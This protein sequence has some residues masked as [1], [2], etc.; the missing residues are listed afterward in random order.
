MHSLHITEWSSPISSMTSSQVNSLLALKGFERDSKQLPIFSIWELFKVILKNKRTGQTDIRHKILSLFNYFRANE[1]QEIAGPLKH[2]MQTS[3]S[4]INQCVADDALFY[5]DAI[6]HLFSYAFSIRL[7]FL[8]VSS[9]NISAKYFGTKSG[10][11]HRILVSDC[12]FIVLKPNIK[13]KSNA[14]NSLSSSRYRKTLVISTAP[15]NATDGDESVTL[16]LHKCLSVATA[17]SNEGESTPVPFRLNS[18]ANARG[19]KSMENS[20][21]NIYDKPVKPERKLSPCALDFQP[22]NIGNTNPIISPRSTEQ[23]EELEYPPKYPFELSGTRVEG[24]SLGRLKFFNEAK[25]YGFIIMDDGSEIFVHKADLVKQSIDTRYLAYFKKYY[26]ILMEF[27]VQEYQ[28]KAKKHRK[29][30]DVIIFD[31]QALC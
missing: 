15:T 24:K 21:L 19:T 1:Q 3:S 25:E 22:S 11:A 18:D 23:V 29:A 27:N 16:G 28:G 2:I 7:E 26:E 20:D 17:Y 4:Y 14:V 6:L 30:V 12:S 5:N 31:M 8:F 13:I 9:T 10:L